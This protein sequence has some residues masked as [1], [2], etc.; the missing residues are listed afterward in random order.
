VERVHGLDD[1]YVVEAT[2]QDQ[3]SWCPKCGVADE[4][5]EHGPDV[6]PERRHF[7]LE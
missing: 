2:C 6:A 4:V 7:A 1:G 3:P 5:Y